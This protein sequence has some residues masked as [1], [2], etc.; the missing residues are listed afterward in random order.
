MCPSL[1]AVAVNVND[2]SWQEVNM[3]P[4][5]CL[6]TQFCQNNLYL[7]LVLPHTTSYQNLPR[8]SFLLCKRAVVSLCLMGNDKKKSI[9]FSLAML[10]TNT[11]IDKVLIVGFQ[12]ES[13]RSKLSTKWASCISAPCVLLLIHSRHH[14]EAIIG[15]VG[16][17]KWEEMPDK[18]CYCQ[19][20]LQFDVLL[21][22]IWVQL[23]WNQPGS[24]DG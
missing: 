15:L 22:Q 13:L 6:A 11:L 19:W 18:R 20:K 9:L 17:I 10:H 23:K 16:E 14:V 21:N 7:S 12:I 3:D 5:C 8:C 2:I 4:S 1:F 24:D